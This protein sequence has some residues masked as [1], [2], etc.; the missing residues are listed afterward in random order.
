MLIIGFDGFSL[1]DSARRLIDDP[2][3]S[4]VILFR[5]NVESLAQVTALTAEIEAHRHGL[6]ICIDQ[7]GGA[8]RRLRDG[9]IDVG[10]MRDIQDAAGAYQAGQVLGS[11]LRKLGINVNFAPVLDV[12]SNPLNPVIGSRSFS[13]DPKVVA[14]LGVALHLGLQSEGVISC[15]KHF[16]GH[17]DTDLDSHL[18]LPILNIDRQRL[19]HL[20][21]IPFY[22]AVQAQFPMI[23]TA[24]ISLP[25]LDPQ[26]PATL[27]PRILHDILRVDM[28]YEGVIVSDDLEMAAVAATYSPETMVTQGAAAG[29][30]VFLMCHD[31]NKQQQAIHA[32]HALPETRQQLSMNRIDS[33]VS[34][35]STPT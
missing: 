20:E 10:P 30:D 2:L 25:L 9:F 22:A 28:G 6:L 31:T 29:I 26:W 24:H 17:G 4:G 1:P 27:S 19:E 11:G 5:R 13:A 34:D 7:E 12:D 23:M 21:L 16:P 8:V 3:V 18:A 33:L 14:E 15:G 32:L 35:F